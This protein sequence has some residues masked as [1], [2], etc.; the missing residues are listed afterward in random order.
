IRPTPQVGIDAA[1]LVD[2]ADIADLRA[3]AAAFLKAHRDAGGAPDLGPSERLPRS[4]ALA[5]GVDAVPAEDLELW[6]EELALDPYV[7]GLAPRRAHRSGRA[8]AP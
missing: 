8:N 7:R 6:L 3:R 5:A 2:R 4:L 1:K